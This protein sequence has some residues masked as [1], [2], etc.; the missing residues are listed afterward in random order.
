MARVLIISPFYSDPPSSGG[1]IRIQ[2]ISRQLCAHAHEVHH[3]YFRDQLNKHALARTYRR[4]TITYHF[5]PNRVPVS[6]LSVGQWLGALF[7]KKSLKG[8]MQYPLGPVKK[9][10]DELIEQKKFDLV[11][12]EFT[13]LSEFT[14]YLK[15]SFGQLPV[16][17]DSHNVETIYDLQEMHE[18]PF[19]ENLFARLFN[20]FLKK[21]EKQALG[22]A[23]KVFVVSEV[24]KKK[25]EE[26]FARLP[27]SKKITVAPNGVDVASFTDAVQNEAIERYDVIFVGWMRYPPNVRAV[28]FIAEEILPRLETP[29]TFAA[30]GGE[31]PEEIKNLSIANPNI[32]VSGTVSDVKPFLLRSKIFVAPLFEGSGTRLKILEAFAAGT[33]VVCTTQAAEG[34]LY[35]NSRDLLIAN[36]PDEFA[37]NIKLLLKNRKLYRDVQLNAKRLAQSHYDWKLTLAPMMREINHCVK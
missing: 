8:A 36:T 17:L 14:V 21:E 27:L 18:K 25:Y 20:T 34:I 3:L 23:D 5:V 22:R 29:I 1:S 12:V 26:M 19:Y 30:V 10:I 31:P 32:F 33:P 7:Q 6:S 24:D 4:N 37:K 28:K 2:H 9:T 13:W 15:D 35:E 11:L 16:F